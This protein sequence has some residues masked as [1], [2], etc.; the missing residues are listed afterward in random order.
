MTS[1]PP[2][3]PESLSGPDQG[4]DPDEPTPVSKVLVA[5]G[6]L[7]VLGAIAWGSMALVGNGDNEPLP[8]ST[9]RPITQPWRPA[10]PADAGATGTAGTQASSDRP[11]VLVNGPI[12]IDNGLGV[13]LDHLGHLGG[14]ADSEHVGSEPTDT[15]GSEALDVF[16]DQN[17]GLSLSEGKLFSDQGLPQDAATRCAARIR[18]GKDGYPALQVFPGDQLCLTTSDGRIAWLRVGE[19][20]SRD[21]ELALQVTVWDSLPG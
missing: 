1:S 6:T 15:S 5:A 18:S 10:D 3:P 14:S 11:V 20:A 12:T 2:P 21:D 17:T 8:V 4:T 13:D 16:W 9:G 7:V 19:G